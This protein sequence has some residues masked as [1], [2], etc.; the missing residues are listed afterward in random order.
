MTSKAADFFITSSR[1]KA[2]T[3]GNESNIN[4][5]LNDKE[6][7]LPADAISR[8]P[9]GGAG[10]KLGLEKN[11]GHT[12]KHKALDYQQSKEDFLTR[13]PEYRQTKVLDSVREKEFTRLK[14]GNGTVYMDYMG[15][16]IYPEAL[17]K[18]HLE[19][20]TS[21]VLGNTH[22]DSPS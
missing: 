10:A 13:F 11:L 2:H 4:V 12:S 22:S 20:L 3:N 17:V 1:S 7:T 9:T 18:Q 19:Q 6:S 8:P 16:C 15:G 14:Q 5:A 21:Q